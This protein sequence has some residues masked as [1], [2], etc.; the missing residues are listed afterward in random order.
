M[1]TWIYVAN[2]DDVALN[3]GGCVKLGG[4]Q[5]VRFKLQPPAGEA[6]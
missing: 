6:M 4:V 5:I 2:S 3:G 1:K